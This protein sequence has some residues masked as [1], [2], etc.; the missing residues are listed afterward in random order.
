MHNV[1]SVTKHAES[2]DAQIITWKYACEIYHSDWSPLE[3]YLKEYDKK[4]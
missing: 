3:H 1:I 4:S 2:T